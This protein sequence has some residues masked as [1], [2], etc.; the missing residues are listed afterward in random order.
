[1]DKLS[2]CTRSVKL[3]VFLSGFVFYDVPSPVWNDSA[4]SMQALAD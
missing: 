4:P 3:I 1:M 2:T